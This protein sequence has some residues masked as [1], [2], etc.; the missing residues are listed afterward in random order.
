MYKMNQ[1]MMDAIQRSGSDYSQK[2]DM[3]NNQF[4]SDQ[5]LANRQKQVYNNA[6]SAAKSRVNTLIGSDYAETAYYGLDF[7][8]KAYK[9]FQT[10]KAQVSAGA[11]QL[12]TKAAAPEAAAPKAAAPEAA[13]GADAA[14]LPYAPDPMAEATANMRAA[15]DSG[16]DLLSRAR[17]ARRA[18]GLVTKGNALDR[19]AQAA[20]EAQAWRKEGLSHYNSRFNPNNPYV[21]ANVEDLKPG[22]QERAQFMSDQQEA[23][24]TLRAITQQD[25]LPPQPLAPTDPNAKPSAADKPP[26]DPSQPADK[27]PV[28][29]TQSD[30]KPS[31]ADPVEKPPVDPEAGAGKSSGF[32]DTVGLAGLGFGIYEEATGSDSATTKAANIAGQVGLYAGVEAVAAINPVLGAAAGAAV[33]LGYLIDDLVTGKKH[34]DQ[35]PAPQAPAPPTM[36]FSSSAVLDSSSYRQPLGSITQ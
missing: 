32:G 30:S 4:T 15:V 17:A 6:V 33:G 9:Q 3:L 18:S 11:S 35:G 24:S 10:A 5:M 27:P 16:G 36:A 22:S 26:V 23:S 21:Q 12:S 34:E 19:R 14:R 20:S 2:Q 7:A 1:F 13:A 29:P 25:P 31:P 8:K 28:D